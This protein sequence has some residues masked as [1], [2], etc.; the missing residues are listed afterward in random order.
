M[1]RPVPDC[2]AFTPPLSG[3]LTLGKG[4][5][6]L[7]LSFLTRAMGITFSSQC[8]CGIHLASTGSGSV[9]GTQGE[10]EQCYF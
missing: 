5:T 4:L 9:A 2:P 1:G 10:L 3:S 8:C 7:C 6:S